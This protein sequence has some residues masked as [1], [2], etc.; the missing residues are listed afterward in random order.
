MGRGS[1]G[2][3]AQIIRH[4]VT[5]SLSS[6]AV[7]ANLNGK[8]LSRK[9]FP[10]HSNLR[11]SL[12]LLLVIMCQAPSRHVRRRSAPPAVPPTVIVPIFL[13]LASSLLRPVLRLTHSL[14][15]NGILLSQELWGPPQFT[16]LPLR[17]KG[18]DLKRLSPPTRDEPLGRAACCNTQ[19]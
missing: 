7:A 18:S 11:C 5:L 1:I 17:N 12:L 15:A 2:E 3:M 6:Y 13:F 19:T 8:H 10:S 9:L 16:A 14:G 4:A